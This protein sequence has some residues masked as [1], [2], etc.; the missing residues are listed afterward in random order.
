MVKRKRI[1]ISMLLCLSLIFGGAVFWGT[2]TAYAKNTKKS[3]KKETVK[4]EDVEVGVYLKS[5]SHLILDKYNVM[6]Q[7][8]EENLCTIENGAEDAYLITLKEGTHW[9][10]FEKEGDG[11]VSAK[12]E[13]DVSKEK[14]VVSV[15]FDSESDSITVGMCADVTSKSDVKKLVRKIHPT[16]KQKAEAKRKKQE[17]KQKKKEEAK[18]KKQQAKEEKEAA[19]EKEV[20]DRIEFALECEEMDDDLYTK[21]SRKPSDYEGKK[22][23]FM[24]HIKKVKRPL[25]GGDDTIIG[26]SRRRLLIRTYTGNKYII[27]DK[28]ND[29]VA[30]TV[31]K[32]GDYV[33]CMGVVKVKEKLVGS[34]E[35][36]INM[37]YCVEEELAD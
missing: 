9:L 14:D 22:V 11:S 32:K 23:C 19:Q 35:M 13:F 6:V 27:K 4:Q 7:I 8:D 36:V 37:K 24:V 5:E 10:H 12:Y 30:Q 16:K 26:Y 28:R 17:E 3:D 31:L 33:L 18:R 21:I 29:K 25:F 20:L 2:H 15:Q 34:D 1:V